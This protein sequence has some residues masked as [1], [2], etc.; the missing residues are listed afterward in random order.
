MNNKTILLVEDDPR[1]IELTQIGLSKHNLANN[2]SIAHDGAEALDYLYRRGEYAERQ[3][4]HPALILLD[5]KMPKVNG[6]EV[7]HEIKSDPDL[8]TIPVVMM[9]SSQEESDVY[10]SYQKGAN[11]YVVKPV[12]F[13]EFMQTIKH[14]GLFWLLQNKTCW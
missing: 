1:D 13:N 5:I 2:L 9:T 12:A 11:A 4:N 7:L 6:L 10:Q 14:L 3:D 8:K